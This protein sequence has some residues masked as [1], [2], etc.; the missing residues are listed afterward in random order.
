VWSYGAQT[1]VHLS[2]YIRLRATLKPYIAELAKN[3]SEQGVPTVRP[4]WWEFPDDPHAIGQDTQYMLGPDYLVAPVTTQNAT[5]RA[6]YFPGGNALR[7][8]HVL[9]GTVVEGGQTKIVA[10]PID[11]IPVYTTRTDRLLALESLER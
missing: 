5:S 9:D 11:S 1:Q 4:L 8:H 7:W 10:A 2:K 3:V 6:V